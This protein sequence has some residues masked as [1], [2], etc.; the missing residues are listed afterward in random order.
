[1]SSAREEMLAS[2][3][4]ALAGT[5]AQTPARP[6]AKAA[7]ARSAPH[8]PA[9]SRVLVELFV[10]RLRDYGARVTPSEP[11][12]IGDR[13]AEACDRHD[14]G[15]LVV[16]SGLPEAW[17]PS[18]VE[19]VVDEALSAGELDSLDGVITGAALGIAE[20]GTIAL[21]GGSDQGRRA[22]TLIPDLHLCVVLAE[23]VVAALPDALEPL[24]TSIR[25][26]RRA[27]TFISGPSATADIELRRVQ[28]VHG[29]RRLEV[30]VCGG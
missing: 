27:I 15:R 26:D 1:M 21:D 19:L 25:A 23:R 16:P 24:S 17:R 9:G 3:R 20:S 6:E 10:D 14:A 12:G 7:P 4:R 5:A 29:P 11:A 13:L 28:G 22:I 8:I 2:I 18:G 30:I